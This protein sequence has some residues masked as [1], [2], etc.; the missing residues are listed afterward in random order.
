MKRFLLFLL[1]IACS[2]TA[3][4]NVYIVDN[5]T[6]NPTAYR[7][8]Q[9]GHDAAAV[10]DTIYVIG[11]ATMYEAPNCTKRLVWIGPG[12][13]LTSNLETQANA[14][15]ARLNG[16]TM[17]EGS[18]NS[19]LVSLTF[20]SNVSVNAS[21]ILIRRCL[22]NT[23][24][25]VGSVTDVCIQQCFITGTININGSSNTQIFNTYI[26]NNNSPI[27]YGSNHTGTTIG[28]C[29]F[30]YTNPYGGMNLAN[31]TCYNSYIV[32]IQAISTSNCTID[33]VLFSYAVFPNGT[34]NRQ[35]PIDSVFTGPGNNETRWQLKANSAGIGAGRSGADI[36]MYTGP[37]PY[38]L[39]G[40]PP[41]P[42]I[43]YLFVPTT[44]STTGG[45]Q[46]D[47]RAKGRN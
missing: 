10:G 42:T 26:E 24:I 7:T 1:C 12:Y 31:S 2:I 5:N 40:I 25:L 4:A 21:N 11:S 9:S 44:A 8:P 35:S 3:F 23:T 39:S 47:F 38:V 34:G 19:Q 15:E 13:Y 45:L 20:Y 17:S 37:Y 27:S 46:V 30:N 18:Q 22:V 6:N 32:S 41:I 33:H 29:I 36:G 16:I 28:H 43:T 14:S